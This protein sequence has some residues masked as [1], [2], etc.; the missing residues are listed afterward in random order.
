MQAGIDP[1][2]REEFIL[3]LPSSNFYPLFSIV[4]LAL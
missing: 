3:D 2:E 1:E 4:G